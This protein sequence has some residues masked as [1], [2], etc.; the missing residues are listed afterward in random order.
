MVMR[1]SVLHH[2]GP[3]AHR[4]SQLSQLLFVS[5]VHVH[6]L[7]TCR[8][9]RRVVHEV[10]EVDEVVDEVVVDEVVLEVVVSTVGADAPPARADPGPGCG[11]AK[12][13]TLRQ[14]GGRSGGPASSPTQCRDFRENRVNVCPGLPFPPGDPL[15]RKM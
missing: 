2:Y 10:V 8:R 13:E 11:T 15:T 14:G 7:A 1:V 12:A 3:T 6:V 4:K 5:A 9:G